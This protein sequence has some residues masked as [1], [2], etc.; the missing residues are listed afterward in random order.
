ME[1]YFRILAMDSGQC[2]LSHAQWSPAGYSLWGHK[3]VRHY[4]VTQQQQ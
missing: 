3:R 2:P 4:L 1:T